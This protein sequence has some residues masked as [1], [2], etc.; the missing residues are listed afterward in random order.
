LAGALPFDE[1]IRQSAALFWFGLRNDESFYLWAAIHRTIDASPAF[2]EY[3]LAKKIAAWAHTNR[4]PNKQEIGFNFA[5]SGL[6][7][8]SCFKYSVLKLK[9]QKHIAVDVLFFFFFFCP[10][11]GLSN[12]ITLM[13]IQ[14]G[15][16]VPLRHRGTG[17]VK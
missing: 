13:Q 8:W 15:R 11:K 2:M 5:W 16:T 1:K 4:E 14:S 3:G 12:G 6:E 17:A 7:L 9:N 10:F